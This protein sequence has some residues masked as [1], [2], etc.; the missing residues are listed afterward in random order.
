[1]IVSDRAPSILSRTIS[2]QNERPRVLVLESEATA[3]LL[4]DVE[5]RAVCELVTVA[6]LAALERQLADGAGPLVVCSWV[7]SLGRML[8][9]APHA[10][11]LIHYGDS[12][13]ESLL[14]SIGH[15]HEVQHAESPTHVLAWIRALEPMRSNVRWHNL[16]GLTV[17]MAGVAGAYDVIDLSNEGLA[18]ELD[19]NGDLEP[20]LPGATLTDLRISR[21]DVIVIQHASAVV[22]HVAASGRGTYRVGCQMTCVRQDG[23]VGPS[24][25]L[26]GRALAAGLIRAAL[27]TSGLVLQGAA[28]DVGLQCTSGAIDGERN[29]LT[30]DAPE[31]DLQPFDVVRGH[32]EVAGCLYRFSSAVVSSSPLRVKLPAQLQESSQ[33]QAARFRPA[34]AIAVTLRSPLSLRAIERTVQDL[35]STGLSI[36]VDLDLELVPVGLELTA[37][38]LVIGDERVRC[39]GTV[40]NVAVLRGRRARCGIELQGLDVTA[41]GQLAELITQ[42][43]F[44]GLHDGAQ[45]S[46]DAL[47]GFFRDSGFLSPARAQLLQPLMPE[48]RRTF[49]ALTTRP[50]RLLKSVVCREGERVVGHISSVRAY[51]DTYMIQHL[52]AA[53]GREAG[54]VLSLGN[55]EYLMQNTDFEFIKIWFHAH[56]RF[57]ARVFGGFARKVP[58]PA[59]CSLKSY[60]HVTLPTAR[61]AFDLHPTADVDVVEA[62]GDELSIAERHFVATEAPILMRSDDLTRGA[63]SLG[64]VHASYRRFGLMRRRRVLLAQQRDVVLGFA[65]VEMSSP[66]LNL[67]DSLS[68]FSIHMLPEGQSE[69]AAARRALLA[70]IQTI[71]RPSGRTHV[72]GLLAP[73][74]ADRYRAIG[75]PV[76]AEISTCVTAHR[77]QLRRFFEH[78]ERLGVRRRRR[79]IA[80]QPP[81]A[82]SSVP[83]PPSGPSE[84][85]T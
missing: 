75:L 38:E 24:R 4:L 46:F 16:S 53:V 18:F 31:H 71:Y 56:N 54:L 30:V 12:L 13:P 59:L 41:R 79:A 23:P 17:Q 66:G 3:A 81:A 55:A 47:L 68:R 48:V 51:R 49:E 42:A 35:S 15:G 5:L 27:E 19:G 10:V 11:R 37:V 52:A 43:Q 67:F 20:L 21:G 69:D 39:R 45:V 82:L 28:H 78:M 7:D 61:G 40:K 63:L 34:G 57:P 50:N 26:R 8:D 2:T 32:F 83:S 1:V 44:P 77:T 60:A 85:G 80:A 25:T 6:D 64:E 9:R 84:V 36:D 62:A 22:R 73:D 33:R 70:A 76:D 14:K 72:S 65:L 29:E 58:D 74:E